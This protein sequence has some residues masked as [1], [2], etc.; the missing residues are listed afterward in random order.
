MIFDSLGVFS[1][2]KFIHAFLPVFS[3]QVLDG[4]RLEKPP[5]APDSTYSVL[6]QCWHRDPEMRPAFHEIMEKLE[7]SSTD[8][9]D[10][11]NGD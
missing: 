5:V 8:Y 3:Q 9:S 6:L 4:F 11:F 2:P 7:D 1:K 10:E